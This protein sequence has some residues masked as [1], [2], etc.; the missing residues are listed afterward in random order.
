[1]VTTTPQYM[2]DHQIR[3]NGSAIDAHIC[4]FMLEDL[5]YLYIYVNIQ[6]SKDHSSAFNV[7]KYN[8]QLYIDRHFIL[9]FL[10]E[11]DFL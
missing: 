7:G 11:L 1:M 8:L 6:I 4:M 3:T 10:R 2:I 5:I 9:S